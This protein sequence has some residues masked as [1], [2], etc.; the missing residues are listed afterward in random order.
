MSTSYWPIKGYGIEID[1]KLFNPEKVCALL[2][3]ELAEGE[4]AEDVYDTCMF[5]DFLNTLLTD[6]ALNWNSTEQLLYDNH[7]YIHLPA[8]L[9]WQMSS[10]E[11]NLSPA[12]T[13]RIIMD[14][15]RPYLADDVDE[16]EIV[17]GIDEV[18]IAGCG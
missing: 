2:E 16:N 14:T 1:I 15:I 5:E 13:E 3:A 11:K 7:Y 6:T 10:H 12:D 9:P 4:S 8:L 18:A 17:K